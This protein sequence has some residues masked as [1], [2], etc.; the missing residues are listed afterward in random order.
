MELSNQGKLWNCSNSPSYVVTSLGEWSEGKAESPRSKH[1]EGSDLTKVF[2]KSSQISYTFK[3]DQVITHLLQ[4]ILRS[5][6]LSHLCK[7]IFSVLKSKKEIKIWKN[8]G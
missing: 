3:F 4:W 8:Q 6:I 2:W 5:G 7:F 1:Q